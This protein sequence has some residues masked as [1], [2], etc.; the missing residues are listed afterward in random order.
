MIRRSQLPFGLVISVGA[1]LLPAIVA[2]RPAAAQSAVFNFEGIPAQPLPL[3]QTQ[4]G[5]S[6][7]FTGPFSV[8]QGPQFRLLAGNVIVTSTGGFLDVQFNRLI[9]SFS[10]IFASTASNLGVPDTFEADTFLSNSLVGTGTAVGT[11]THG[12]FI[13]PGSFPE[14]QL[15]YTGPVFDRIRFSNVVAIDSL[16][17]TAAAPEPSGLALL[18]LPC[19]AYARRLRRR[20]G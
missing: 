7:V 14:G 4:N 20:K 12:P 15:V 2:A 10:V 8:A 13:P 11:F 16:S 19:A 1:L 5:I 3:T 17:V 6:A 18:A 9:Q